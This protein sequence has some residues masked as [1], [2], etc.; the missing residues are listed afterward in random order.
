[1]QDKHRDKGRKEKKDIEK[2]E[3]KERKEK[4]RS[5]E[6]HRGKKEKKDKHR[7]KDRKKEKEKEKEKERQKDHSSSSNDKKLPLSTGVINEEKTPKE[8][9]PPSVLPVVQ[10]G[11]RSARKEKERDRYGNS[12]PDRKRPAGQN[13]EKMVSINNNS[14]RD[15]G[16]DNK[17]VQEL[18]KRVIDSRTS[19]TQLAEK[20]MAVERKKDDDMVQFLAR[21]D[22]DIRPKGKEWNKERRYCEQKVERVNGIL[23]VQNFSG[24]VQSRVQEVTTPLVQ[25]VEREMEQREKFK[26]REEEGKWADK[27]KEKDWEKNGQGK[28]REEE[29][30]REKSEHN[31]HRGQE[32]L[33]LSRK[34]DLLSSPNAKNLQQPVKEPDKTAVAV[35]KKRKE[36]EANG[37]LHGEF[38]LIMLH[39]QTVDF[40]MVSSSALHAI[41]CCAICVLKK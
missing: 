9:G 15:I 25:N 40:C 8:K 12:T 34:N 36:P 29:R 37:F 22:A 39:R 4:D 19:G 33:M 14:L 18:E 7:E 16:D 38:Y 3:G 1:M 6:K 32:R 23:K 21:P 26:G 2:R 13:V 24:A 17:Y 28:V 35:I 31:S 41:L 5:D 10:A 27:W 30:A 11:D 20:F